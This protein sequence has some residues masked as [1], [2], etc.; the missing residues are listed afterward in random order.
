MSGNVVAWHQAVKEAE[1][2]LTAIHPNRHSTGGNRCLID[3]RGWRIPRSNT[4]ASRIYKQLIK[5]YSPHEISKNLD[6]RYSHVDAAVKY[7]RR[8]R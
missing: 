6:L 3:K 1:A 5:G 8:E 2:I 4:R 7:I